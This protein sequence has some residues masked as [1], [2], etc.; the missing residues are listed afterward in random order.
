MAIIATLA[1]IGVPVYLQAR[2]RAA[3][4]KAIGDIVILQ[5]EIEMY[6]AFEGDRYPAS[7][8]TIGRGFLRDPWGNL[9]QYLN[10]GDA[11]GLGKMRKDR[12]LVPL[13]S[14]Y[15]LYSM[16]KDGQTSAP[17]TAKASRDDI[18]RAND[19]AFIGLASEY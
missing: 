14:R 13:N 10:F 6:A 15:D 18:V 11:K 19:G 4:V 1:G 17:L 9:Y 16:G 2:E 7:L 3:N 5:R 12:F 8:D